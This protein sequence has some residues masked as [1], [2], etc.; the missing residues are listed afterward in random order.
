MVRALSS[1]ARA[2]ETGDIAASGTFSADVTLVHRFASRP[3]QQPPASTLSSTIAP[4]IRLF[5]QLPIVPSRNIGLIVAQETASAFCSRCGRLPCIAS[6][7]APVGEPPHQ[8]SSISIPGCMSRPHRLTSIC[9][10][11]KYGNSPGITLRTNSAH[12]ASAAAIVSGA[13]RSSSAIIPASKI[14]IF[15]P[16]FLGKGYAAVDKFHSG[17]YN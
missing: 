4:A 6:S 10:S 5:S 7:R 16:A 12:A 17:R 11:V 9:D 2:K 14:R 8:P 1:T 15:V 13:R 3:A